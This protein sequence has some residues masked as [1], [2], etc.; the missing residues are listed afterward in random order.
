MPVINEDGSDS[1]QFDNCLELLVM[2]GRELPHAMMMMI[3]EPWENHE[4]MDPER[5]R[6]TNTI[7]ASLNPGMARPRWH[8]RTAS[9]S[10]R[11][12]I[13][14]GCVPRA[15]TSPR[16]TSS[17]WRRKPACCRWRRSASPQGPPATRPH[18][19]HR[20]RAGTH[21]RRRG[22][23][24]EVRRRASVS[25]VAGQA[26]CPARKPARAATGHTEPDRTGKSC[27][28]SRRSATRTKTCA[29]SSAR[30]P[31]RRPAA[32]FHGHGHAAGG[33]LEPVAV[34]L[35]L[36]QTVVCAGHQPAD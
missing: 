20:H 8:S 18:V 12:S 5:A 19:S 26:S 21:H 35:Q 24:K 23:E 15:I 32:G 13:A 31:A 16:T 30:W 25:R 7:L 1:A 33:A 29:S 10:V 9:A 27:S 36:F 2:A 6:F 4:S 34:A 28:S 22:T 14:T 11:A 3:P 17:S